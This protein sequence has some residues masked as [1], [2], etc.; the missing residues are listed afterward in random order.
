MFRAVHHEGWLAIFCHFPHQADKNRQKVLPLCLEASKFCQFMG[1]V[2]LV[3]I[4]DCSHAPAWEH[5]A[6]TL[7]CI[8]ACT[9]GLIAVNYL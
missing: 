5:M 2:C 1:I 8:I 6:V 7:S 3:M 9:S 4:S